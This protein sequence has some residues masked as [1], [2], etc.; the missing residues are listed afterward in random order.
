MAEKVKLVLTRPDKTI[1]S[2][3]YAG[4]VLPGYPDK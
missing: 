4:I 3:T 2:G 1:K